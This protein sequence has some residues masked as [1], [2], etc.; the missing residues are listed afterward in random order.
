MN[1]APNQYSM[2]SGLLADHQ[3]ASEQEQQQQQQT[4]LAS[5][6]LDNTS[7]SDA[8]EAHANAIRQAIQAQQQQQQ[9]EQLHQQ[10][11]QYDSTAPPATQPSHTN[12]LPNGFNLAKPKST[13][14]SPAIVAQN[15]KEA[16]AAAIAA[17]DAKSAAKGR[18]RNKSGAAPNANA[19][20]ASPFLSPSTSTI[21]SGNA[22]IAG[23]RK[24]GKRAAA[25]AAT[26]AA[27]EAAANE[28][29]GV[30]ISPFLGAHASGS[31][32]TTAPSTGGGET[33]KSSHKVA[34]QRRRDS[35]KLC[36]EELRFILPPINPDEDEDYVGKRP[37]ENNVGG[38]R[39]KSQAMDPKHP[40]KGISKVA[41]LRKSNEC[42]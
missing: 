36:F 1:L 33:R 40:N 4:D 7:N 42:E 8:M 39:G 17:K 38:Q 29:D 28:M 5:F 6:S 26:M 14:T 37:G 18:G 12:D 3:P 13:Q 24:T 35:L 16:A 9:Q 19:E 34:E 27:K 2:L 32:S 41:L 31:A 15:I 20:Q 10:S 21:A 25:Q 30:E 22:V 23:G 11:M